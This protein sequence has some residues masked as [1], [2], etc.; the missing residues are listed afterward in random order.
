MLTAMENVGKNVLVSIISILLT[1]VAVLAI[2]IVL[3]VTGNI[4]IPSKVTIDTGVTQEA[5]YVTTA[6]S[7]ALITDFVTT[8]QNANFDKGVVAELT[9]QAKK[10][11]KHIDDINCVFIALYNAAT[12]RDEDEFDRYYD[13]YV[14]LLFE[15]KNPS[16][17][18][19][20]LYSAESLNMFMK[21]V[22]NGSAGEKTQN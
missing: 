19:G 7:D 18:F 11:N 17:K 2:F 22:R 13:R 14:T 20:V 9:E 5:V 3:L 10:S 6:C 15:K 1:V 4:A 12:N 16:P 21:G 8:A